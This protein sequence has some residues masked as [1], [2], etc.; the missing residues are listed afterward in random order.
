MKLQYQNKPE[1]NFSSR[2]VAKNLQVTFETVT[3][4]RE[5]EPT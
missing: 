4:W 3:A 1:N 5:L 2:K